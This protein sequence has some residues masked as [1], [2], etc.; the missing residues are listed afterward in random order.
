MDLNKA[1]VAYKSSRNIFE[2]FLMVGEALEEISSLQ[3]YKVETEVAI[4]H[5][6]EALNKANLSLQKVMNEVEEEKKKA[7]KINREAGEFRKKTKLNAE[8]IIEEANEKATH[9]VAE[10][11]SWI[12]VAKRKVAD[13]EAVINVSISNLNKEKEAVSRQLVQLKEELA[14][15]KRRLG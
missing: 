15:L 9:I 5:A 11:V 12:E 10:A 1:V 3:N 2:A 8:F 7:V 4:N 14:K 6:K 13:E